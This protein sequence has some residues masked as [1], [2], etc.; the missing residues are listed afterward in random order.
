[1]DRYRS[2]AFLQAQTPPIEMPSPTPYAFSRLFQASE[3][4]SAIQKAVFEQIP[5]V[6]FIVDAVSALS[7]TIEPFQNTLTQE[8]PQEL[9]VYSSSWVIFNM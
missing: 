8:V 6:S 5:D 1:M 3:I 2:F 4:L 7:K 9:K